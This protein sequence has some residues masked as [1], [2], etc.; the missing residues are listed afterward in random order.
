MFSDDLQQ[1]LEDV[2]A[3]TVDINHNGTAYSVIGYF[4]RRR[5]E[6]TLQG[7]QVIDEYR[8]VFISMLDNDNLKNI[9]NDY[10]VSDEYTLTSGS[11]VYSIERIIR[12]K[13]VNDFYVVGIEKK[14]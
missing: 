2:G 5:V 12:T 11:F 6:Q 7:G 14:I 3:D 8:Q 13:T 1:I 9:I 10:D 4:S